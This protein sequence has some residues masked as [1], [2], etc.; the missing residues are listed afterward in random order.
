MK[1][2][3]S[4]KNRRKKSFW[5]HTPFCFNDII[6]FRNWKTL[7]FCWD[8]WNLP[9]NLIKFFYD[10]LSKISTKYR[11]KRYACVFPKKYVFVSSCLDV[12]QKHPKGGIFFVPKSRDWN[13]LK[14]VGGGGWKLPAGNNWIMIV[15]ILICFQWETNDHRA[16]FICLLLKMTV[17]T[18]RQI[19]CSIT[20]AEKEG[21]D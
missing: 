6:I 11:Q 2:Y 5:N 16:D 19:S 20:E 10:N 15:N 21:D 13:A 12:R 8:V 9:Q 14:K 3:K 1:S 7:F 17:C 4:R 18:L